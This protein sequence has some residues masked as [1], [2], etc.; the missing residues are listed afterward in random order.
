MLLRRV[1]AKVIFHAD[2]SRLS[3]AVSQ[4][5]CSLGCVV[6]VRHCARGMTVSLNI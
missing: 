1:L 3:K 4:I 2:P 5:Q 6:N